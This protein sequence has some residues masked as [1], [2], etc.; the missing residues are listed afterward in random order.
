VFA[1]FQPV[2]RRIQSVVDRRFNRAR[3]D[4]EREVERFAAHVRDEVEVERVTDALAATLQRTMQPA[5]AAL[6]LRAGG[7]G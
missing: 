3:Y 2:R 7:K 4:A 5:S 1:L 6:W